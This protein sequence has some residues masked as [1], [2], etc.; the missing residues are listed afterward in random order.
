MDNLKQRLQLLALFSIFFIYKTIS[1][2]TI[3]EMSLWFMITLVYLI[4]LMIAY[5]T[6][7]GSQVTPYKPE[8]IDEKRRMKQN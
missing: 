3:E 8:S 7:R 5:L 2:Q 6:L 4:S 1:S